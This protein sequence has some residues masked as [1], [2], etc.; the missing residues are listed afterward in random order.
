MTAAATMLQDSRA[1]PGVFFWNGA[2]ERAE[3][4]AWL[5][6]SG[7]KGLIPDGVLAVW[8]ATG[9]GDM[10]DSETIL[11]PFGDVRLGDN[12]LAQRDW[13]RSRGLAENYIPIVDGIFFGAVDTDTGHIVELDR[14]TL[15][16]LQR[17]G[18]IEDWYKVVRQEFG[19]AYGL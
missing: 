16:A 6:Q 13:L 19:Q 4:D 14:D 11:G 18:T 2:I 9:G 15:E 5:S 3:L 7:L 10:F 12:V 1:R 8:E 17:I